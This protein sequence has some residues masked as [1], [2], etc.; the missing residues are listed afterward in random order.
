MTTYVTYTMMNKPTRE[1]QKW[2]FFFLFT[3][4]IDLK[5][6]FEQYKAQKIQ[7]FIV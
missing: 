5:E 6:F 4:K 1:H 2:Y 7:I 3:P